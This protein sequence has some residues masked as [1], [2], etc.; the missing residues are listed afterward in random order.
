MLLK[1]C[2]MIDVIKVALFFVILVI[3]YSHSGAKTEGKVKRYEYDEDLPFYSNSNPNVNY[4]K[5]NQVYYPRHNPSADN[6]E[7]QNPT[8]DEYYLYD[9]YYPDNVAPPADKSYGYPSYDPDAD[10]EYYPS[11]EDNT[12]FQKPLFDRPMFNN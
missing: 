8:E 1:V 9:G 6:P 7:N 11:A 2:H 10:N 12:N 3:N 4:D 5:K